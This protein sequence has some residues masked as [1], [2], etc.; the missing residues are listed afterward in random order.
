MSREKLINETVEKMRQFPDSKIQEVLNFV[1]FLK[2]TIDDKK[3]S[4]GFETLASSS[5]SNEFLNEEEEDL[6]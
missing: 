2:S 5:K 3:I 4:E 6:Y 1:N